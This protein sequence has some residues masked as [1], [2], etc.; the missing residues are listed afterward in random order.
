M[1]N[2]EEELSVKIPR[3]HK[4][5]IGWTIVDIK[6][7]SPSMVQHMIHLEEIA[8]TSREP[9]RRLISSM[10]EVVRTELLKLVDTSVIYLIFDSS[11]VSP[12]QVVPKQSGIT[13]L[14]NEKNE[15]VPTRIYTE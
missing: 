8:K 5:A 4:E 6:G 9:Q 15:L 7:I 13:V 3:D 1:N 14:K 2:V 10:K 12:V 11:W